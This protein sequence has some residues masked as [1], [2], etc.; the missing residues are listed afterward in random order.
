MQQHLWR[1]RHKQREL[2]LHQAQHLHSKQRELKL[3]QIHNKQ[4]ELKLQ[5]V[6]HCDRDNNDNN[7]DPQLKKRVDTGNCLATADVARETGDTTTQLP[8]LQHRLHSHTASP[9]SPHLAKPIRQ[10]FY[11]GPGL[12]TNTI[13]QGLPASSSGG[14]GLPGHQRQSLALDSKNKHKQQLKLQPDDEWA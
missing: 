8:N 1:V 11:S 12:G 4:R 13:V 14:V 3:Q 9:S 7:L 10:G 6:H 5:Q 2:K